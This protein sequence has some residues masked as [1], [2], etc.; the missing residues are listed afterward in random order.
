MLMKKLIDSTRTD[1]LLATVLKVI[2][3]PVH[4]LRERP[5]AA[6]GVFTRIYA[7]NDWK[8]DESASG[9]GSTLAYTAG[10]RQALPALFEKFAVRS[11]FDAPCGD[12][13]WM[14]VLLEDVRIDYTGGDI[15]K[16]LVDENAARYGG[17]TRRF[18]HFDLTRDAFPRA[19]L[20]FCRDCLFHLSF[21][22]TRR[23]LR[24]F[25]DSD[26]P[27]VLTTTHKNR[28][29]FV[30]RD[31]PTGSYKPMDLFSAPYNFPRDVL[32]RIDDWVAPFPER[33]MCLW[34]RQQIAA[35]L[36]SF[37]P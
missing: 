3:Y 22:D 21:D 16:T 28:D 27:Y 36:K 20:W 12:F 13:N 9:E 15:V 7:N 10:L 4:R 31:I 26:I 18:V 1:G 19:D 5:P 34:S 6:E 14:R 17:P 25:V 33:E 35:A 29:G 37:D 32:Y 11:M 24:R 8:S 23:A 2:R 30:N